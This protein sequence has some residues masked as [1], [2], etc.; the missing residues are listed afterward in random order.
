MTLR[1]LACI[2]LVGN[3]ITLQAGDNPPL[4]AR[5]LGMAGAATALSGDV[6]G[7]QN[8]QA[9]LAFIEKFQA[10]GFYET[11]F[12]M[13]DLGMKAFA[14]GIP[15]K[16]GVF[17]VSV[18]SFGNKLYSENKA[19]LA[20][21]RKFGPK[22]SAA[23]QLNFHN[24]RIAENYGS[25][26]IATAEVGFMAEPVKNLT[27]GFH[28]FNPTRS[29]LSGNLAER[30]PTVMKLGALCRFSDKV[31]L[32]GEAEKDADYKATF[33]AG[34]EYRPM[35]SFYLRGGAASNPG[36]SAFGMGIIMQNLRLDVASTFHSV[37]GFSP[38]ISLQY[39]L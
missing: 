10:A 14:A 7:T 3:C 24:T 31:F 16:G 27:L 25:A 37:L 8:N 17:G 12:L 34:I 29:K 36:L 23:V 11:R 32:T 13:N 30:M 39:G 21:A 28:L 20:Y 9:S 15:I 6:W 4:G 5:A 35:P 38:S 22:I 19:G 18:N 2:L 1:W 26:S 33:R